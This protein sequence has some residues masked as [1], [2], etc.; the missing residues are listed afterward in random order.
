M[1]QIDEAMWVIHTGTAKAY[2]FEG[3]EADMWRAVVAYGSSDA[4]LEHVESRPGMRDSSLRNRLE[5]FV[6]YL[7]VEGLIES[8]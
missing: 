6:A 4:S 3:I 8:A 2:A 5:T 1:G 7:A